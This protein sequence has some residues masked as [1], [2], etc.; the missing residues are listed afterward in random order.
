MTDETRDIARREVAAQ[1]V[2]LELTNA[3]LASGARVD[4]KT[5]NSFLGAQRRWPTRLSRARICEALRWPP[6]E[7]DHIER[8]GKLSAAARDVYVAAG[9]RRDVSNDRLIAEI[10]ANP[11][12]D[13][14]TKREWISKVRDTALSVAQETIRDAKRKR[15]AKD[16]SKGVEDSTRT[17]T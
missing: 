13:A 10:E 4:P 7:L 17:G 5:V 3:A 15:N 14:A 9:S 12:L 8:T 16:S 11:H 2:A 1:M 6:D